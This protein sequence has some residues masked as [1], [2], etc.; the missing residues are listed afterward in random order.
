[1]PL[2]FTAPRLDSE[3]L[4]SLAVHLGRRP[5]VLAWARTPDGV[6]VGLPGEMLTRDADGGWHSQPW[7]EIGRGNWDAESLVLSWTDAANASHEV[8]LDGSRRFPELFN[9]R[10]TASVI[11]SRR[12]DLGKGRGAVV[13]L[14]RNLDP[15][16][17]ETAWRVTP[18]GKTDPSDPATRAQLDQLL[19]AARAELAIT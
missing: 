16:S 19:A 10:V 7:H 6:V 14:R 15:A 18:T 9:E 8:T 5:R 17:D 1:M 12:V 2:P 4:A 11:T 3:V 13:A